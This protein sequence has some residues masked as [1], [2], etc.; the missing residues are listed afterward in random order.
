[1]PRVKTSGILDGGEE[2]DEL[3]VEGANMI[4]MPLF[5]KVFKSIVY[6]GGF[7]AC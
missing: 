4:F 1:L 3:D 5:L 2:S 6:D 7:C